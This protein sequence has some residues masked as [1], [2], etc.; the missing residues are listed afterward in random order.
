MITL[1]DNALGRSTNAAS[2]QGLAEEVEKL[3]EENNLFTA[4]P[5]QVALQF[6]VSSNDQKND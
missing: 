2:L 3:A 4:P 5:G 6:R 1:V